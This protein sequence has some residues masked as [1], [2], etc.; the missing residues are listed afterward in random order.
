M[1]SHNCLYIL[2]VLTLI[3]GWIATG[4]AGGPPEQPIV[5][6]S[7]EPQRYILEQITGDR[8]QVRSLLTEGANPETY[9][10]SVTHM[11]NLGKSIC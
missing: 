9:D 7:I 1:K 3:S 2:I 5:T 8:V 6:V 10:P 4:C 11:H